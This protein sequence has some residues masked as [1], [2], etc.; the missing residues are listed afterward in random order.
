MIL[1]PTIGGVAFAHVYRAWRTRVLFVKL[2]EISMAVFF[3][4]APVMTSRYFHLH[5]WFAGWLLGMHAN[6]DVWWSRAVMAY[7]WV[8]CPSRFAGDFPRTV[9]VL[10]LMFLPGHVHQRDCCI[11]EGPDLDLR[12]CILLDHR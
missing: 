11:W 4:L 7:C 2:V 10:T 3:F 6:F 1:I 12:I 5:H 8:S 9:Q